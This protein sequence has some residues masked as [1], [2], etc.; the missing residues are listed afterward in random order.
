VTL[1][2]PRMMLA[3][4]AGGAVGSVLRYLVASLG[5]QLGWSTSGFPWWTLGINV[6]GSF[7]LG[8]LSRYL[9]GSSIPPALFFA[10]TVGVCGGYTTFSTFSYE[11]L[12]LGE[13][14]LWISGAAYAAASLLLG[15]AAVVLGATVGRSMRVG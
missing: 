2:A 13:R 7:L 1:P 14:G 15:L 5:P 10:L 6:T 4:A 9:I 12:D 11:L 3:V 8:F